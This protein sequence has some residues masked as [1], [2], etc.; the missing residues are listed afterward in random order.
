MEAKTSF[1]IQVLSKQI[2]TPEELDTLC[3]ELEKMK[4]TVQNVTFT[5]NSYSFAAC[6]RLA[7]ILEQCKLLKVN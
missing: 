1:V 4:A 5:G 2:N 7:H 6:A 3:P